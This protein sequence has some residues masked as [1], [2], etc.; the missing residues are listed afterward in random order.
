MYLRVVVQAYGDYRI[1]GHDLVRAVAVPVAKAVLGGEVEV[2][3]LDGAV[4]LKIPAGTQPG[5]KF[6]IKG[7]GLPSGKDTRGD[8]Y[9]EVKVSIPTKLS[10]DERKLWEE[11]AG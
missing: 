7:R 1:D 8:F 9:A 2:P 10:D 11:L 3:T 6:R 5:Q 4:K